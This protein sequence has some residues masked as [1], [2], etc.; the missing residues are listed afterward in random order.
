MKVARGFSFTKT[1]EC[2][3]D[4]QIIIR[5]LR[6]GIDIEN[7]KIEIKREWYKIKDHD[8][9]VSSKAENEFLKDLVALANTPGIEGYLIIGISS[10][11][12]VN[13]SPFSISGLRDQSDLYNL[14]VKR[15]D[16]PVYF[17]LYQEQYN[18]NGNAKIITVIK[19]PPSLS[20]PHIIRRYV[21]P[22]GN[23]IQN[24][25]PIRKGTSINS[26]NKYDLEYMIYDRKNIEPDYALDIMVHE[27]KIIFN[28]SGDKINVNFQVVF[29]NYGRKPVGIVGGELI[30]VGD[31]AKSIDPDLKMILT[32]YTIMPTA[33]K[34]YFNHHFLTIGSNDIQPM[35]VFF[36]TEKKY[37][38]E[39]LHALRCIDPIF[40]KVKIQSITG[41]TFQSNELKGR[42]F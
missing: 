27:P 15:V 18:D 6:E 24:F 37:Y 30:M 7:P 29:V 40:V 1:E 19:V 20:K 22:S 16:E 12:N 9:D 28:M 21:T 34:I 33:S 10:D 3:M 35:I 13:D 41:Q 5:K 31:S 17:E 11:G 8:R 39:M 38:S 32:S 14:V 2:L 26:A 4:I 36:E 23:E 25:I 42:K